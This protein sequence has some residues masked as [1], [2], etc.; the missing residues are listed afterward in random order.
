[1]EFLS[2]GT[3]CFLCLWPPDI[4]ALLGVAMAT[5]KRYS[6]ALGPGWLQGWVSPPAGGPGGGRASF[7]TPRVWHKRRQAPTVYTCPG[8]E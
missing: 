6:H 8:C 2:L 4:I 1:M 3:C 7:R 5:D